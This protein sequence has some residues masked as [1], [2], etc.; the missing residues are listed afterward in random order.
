MLAI[1]ALPASTLSDLEILLGKQN[2]SSITVVAGPEHAAALKQLKMD[3]YALI[4]KL[5]REIAVATTIKDTWQ[6]ID[7]EEIIQDVTRSGSG[8]QGVLCSPQFETGLTDPSILS[9]EDGELEGCLETSLTFL[10]SVSKA[11]IVHLLSRCKP[12]AGALNDSFRTTPRGPSF[13]VTGQQATSPAARIAKAACD[14]LILQLAQATSTQRL[15]VGYT[16]ALLIPEPKRVDTA[17]ASD[18]PIMQ[19]EI[20]WSPTYED[21]VFTP[22]ES[23]TKL[24]AMWAMQEELA[25]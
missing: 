25:S 8:I 14:S 22:G 24:Y 11:T 1:G 16:D 10:H 6:Q 20:P 4:G 2:F 23:P 7:I 12:S 18:G 15:A 13:L 17:Q 19:P 21:S 9:M 5:R 3:I